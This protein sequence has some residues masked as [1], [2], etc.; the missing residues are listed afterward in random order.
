MLTAGADGTARVWDAATGVELQRFM[1]HGQAVRSVAISAE[2]S[3]VVTG[4]DDGSAVLW[5]VANGT[6][7]QRFTGHTEPVL[8]VAFAP[9]GAAVLTGSEDETAVLW[10]AGSGELLQRFVGHT[11]QVTQVAFSPDG[12]TVL[13]GSADQTARLWDTATGQLLRQFV[14]HTSPLQYAGFAENGNRVITGDARFIYTWRETL[15]EVVE[16]ACER[17]ARDFT[18]EERDF[19]NI[20][21]A[22]P[23]CPEMSQAVAQAEPTWTPII[24]TPMP[25]DAISSLVDLEFM[26]LDV[27]NIE[28]GIPVQHVYLDTGDDTVVRPD[29]MGPLILSQPLFTSSEYVPDDYLEPP[30]D[31]GPFPKGEPLG[32]RMSAWIAATGQGTY[33]QEGANAEVHL[34]FDDLVPDGIY[35]LWCVALVFPT[36]ELIEE[37]PCGAPDGADNNFTTDATGHG[38]I[39][40]TMD[41]FP[42]S[43]NEIIYELAIAYHSDGLTYGPVV[44]ERGKNAHVQMI[45][46]FLPP[47]E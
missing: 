6:E 9:D 41:A 28:M 36:F 21:T 7:L 29:N 24:T 39:Q 31:L 22:D 46:D 44:G 17:L 19:Y 26:V 43:S 40:L 10:D 5:N 20:S 42:P 16:F 3:T 1:D 14:G 4:S 8:S 23:T 2:G 47:E 45:Y 38:E 11:D 35:T 32:F 34:Q 30:F 15:D 25:V 13:T 33:R 37:F 27:A 18:G 12:Q